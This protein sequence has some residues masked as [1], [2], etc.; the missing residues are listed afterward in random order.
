MHT[1]NILIKAPITQSDV[2][3]QWCHNKRDGV[4]NHQPHDCLLNSFSGADQ[5]TRQISASLAFVQ[6][7]HRWP[8]GPVTLKMFPFDDVITSNRNLKWGIG[9]AGFNAMLCMYLWC[10]MEFESRS[11]YRV[12]QL[13]ALWFWLIFGWVSDLL[14]IWNSVRCTSFV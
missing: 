9:G 11:L 13:Y 14:F 1:N 6:G 4:S 8:K 7:I 12:S 3:L 5:R 10:Y 2:T